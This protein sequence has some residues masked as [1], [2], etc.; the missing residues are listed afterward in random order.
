[1]TPCDTYHPAGCERP[2]Q[3]AGK[4]IAGVVPIVRDAAQAS[5]QGQQHQQELQQGSKQSGPGPS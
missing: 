5:V 3:E 1:M 4:H 2:L